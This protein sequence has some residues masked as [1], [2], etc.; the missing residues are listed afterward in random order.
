MNIKDS[1]QAK[2][3][4]APSETLNIKRKEITMEKKAI[5]VVSQGVLTE[6]EWTNAQGEKVM[7]AS[8]QMLF[9]DGIDSFFAEATDDLARKLEKEPIADGRVVNLQLS[10][11]ARSKT[12]TQTGEVKTW[13]NIRILKIVAL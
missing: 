6:R 11:I 13:T 9:N 4:K 7:L 10:L 2:R 3:R 12:D 8:K 1:S 5:K